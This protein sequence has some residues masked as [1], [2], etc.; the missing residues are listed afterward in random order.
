V[1]TA[2]EICHES[3]L[4]DIRVKRASDGPTAVFHTTTILMYVVEEMLKYTKLG[5]LYGHTVNIVQACVVC[6][7]K[8]VFELGI[9]QT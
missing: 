7:M 4:E 3:Q 8:S 6:D 1:C 2:S 5:N 9:A